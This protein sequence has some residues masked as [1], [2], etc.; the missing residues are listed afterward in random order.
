MDSEIKSI[1]KN[2]TWTVTELPAGAKRI[3]VK[4]VYKTKYT[5]HEKIDKYKA[6]LV[7]KGYSQKYG[8]DY[9]E[10]F[11]PVARMDTVWMIIALAVHKNWT[12]SQMNVKSAFLHGELSEDVYV[13]Q[14][15]GYEKKGSEHLV[16]KLH[17]ALYGLKQ[18]P[19]AWFSRIEAH[20]ID[21]GFQRCNSEQTLFTK[22]SRKGRITI[23]SV[24][25]DDLFFIGNDE[26]MMSEF[27]SSML[28]E[29]DMFNLRKMRFFSWN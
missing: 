20:F 27:K 14:P 7:A 26:V 12:I 28:R 2:Q 21:E 1:E 5:E 6:R 19:R 9:T 25:V 23:V 22:R 18:A 8:V 11:A 29:S 15:K 3:G 4:W 17:K 16:Y 10:V 24:Y 13:E